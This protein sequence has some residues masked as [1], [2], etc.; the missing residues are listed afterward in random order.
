MEEKQKKEL[1][2]DPKQILKREKYWREKFNSE[3][4]YAKVRMRISIALMEKMMESY[5]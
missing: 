5:K 1:S 4:Q 2:R 3:R